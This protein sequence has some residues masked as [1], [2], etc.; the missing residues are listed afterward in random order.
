MPKISNVLKILLG[1][2]LAILILTILFFYGYSSFLV[3]Q[4]YGE[5]VSVFQAW[6][7]Y[8][9]YLF[10]KI[11]FVKNF[12]NYESLEVMTA[13][14]YFE[15]IYNEYSQ[16]LESSMKEIENKEKALADKE[17]Q[18]DKL[19][20][21]IK[22]VEESWKEKKLKEELSKV[23][24]TVTLKRLQDIVDTFLNSDPAQLRRLMNADNMSVE[25]LAIVFSKLPSD[26]R[27]EMLQQLTSIN[28]TKAAQVVEKMGGVD[29]II[30]D[31]DFKVEELKNAISDMVNTEAELVTLSGFSKGVSAFLRDMNYDELW[32]FILKIK[33]RPDLVFY[34]LS[35][36]DNATMVRLLKDIKDKEEELFIEI[37]NRGAKF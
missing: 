1:I 22:A 15:K 13:R 6:R 2:L 31:I 20:S 32:N 34:V 14:E 23:Q 35:N 36:V 26:T 24:D 5:N 17:A 33:S 21:S 27:A 11:P 12:V 9:S 30:S 18:V 28:P 3:K 19:F 29:Q 16:Q 8:V 4:L 10:S 37:M 7:S 25:T